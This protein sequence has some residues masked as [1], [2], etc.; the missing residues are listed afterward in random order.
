MELGGGCAGEKGM[1]RKQSQRRVEEGPQRWGRRRRGAELSLSP[2]T[3]EEVAG[4]SGDPGEVTA[5]K[6][7][8]T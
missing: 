1:I 5:G 6:G 4:D 3:R 7:F 2:P 8:G